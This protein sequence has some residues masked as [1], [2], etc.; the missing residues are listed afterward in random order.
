MFKMHL[1]ITSILNISEQ[2]TGIILSV[3]VCFF[4]F[5]GHFLYNR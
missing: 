3:C 2:F 5:F 1:K 4:F